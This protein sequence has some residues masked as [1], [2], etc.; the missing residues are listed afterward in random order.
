M[1]CFAAGLVHCS[2]SRKKERTERSTPRS[3]QTSTNRQT[4]AIVPHRKMSSSLIQLLY[5]SVSGLLNLYLKEANENW[6][7]IESVPDLQ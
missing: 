6:L 3:E 7:Q 2:V 5:L 4:F 1:G